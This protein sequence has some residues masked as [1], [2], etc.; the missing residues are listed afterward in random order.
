MI[1]GYIISETPVTAPNYL[2]V[3]DSIDQTDDCLPKLIVGWK[4][5]KRIESNFDILNKQINEKTFWTYAKL[6]LWSTH[7]GDLQIFI[8]FCHQFLLDSTKYVFLDTVKLTLRQ[9]RRAYRHLREKKE[10]FCL[11]VRDMLYLYDTETVYGVCFKFIKPFGYTE[12]RV[13]AHLSRWGT[14]KFVDSTILDK[15]HEIIE[16][17]SGPNYLSIILETGEIC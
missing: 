6:E 7:I 5:A 11:I 17:I 2:K 8:N 14:I 9:Q 15:H 13:K 16:A 10:L 4:F 1:I 12:D 3:V